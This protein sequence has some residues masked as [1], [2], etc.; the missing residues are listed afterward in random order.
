MT[1]RA[2][3]GLLVLAWLAVVTPAIGQ[4]VRPESSRRLVR[5]WDFEERAFHGEPVPQGWYRAQ[6]LPPRRE[7]P[8]YPRWNEGVLTR[9]TAQSGEFSLMLPTQGG[10]TSVILSAAVLPAMPGADYA[11]FGGIRTA[12]LKNARA[13]IIAWYLDE[14]LREI[15]GTRVSSPL[16]LSE[17]RWTDAHLILLGHPGAAWMEIEVALL[18]PQQ[19]DTRPLPVQGL[20]PG[21]FNGAAY[22]DDLAVYQ[23]PRA[24]IR[25]TAP[26]NIV[27][28]PEP[29]AL[30]V[31]LRDLT[32][33]TLSVTLSVFDFEGMSVEERAITPSVSGRPLTMPLNL[34]GFGWY[35]AVLNVRNPD[36]LVARAFS[37][38][39][40]LPAGESPPGARGAFGLIAEETPVEQF[41]DLPA[42]V[43]RSGVGAVHLPVWTRELSKETLDS[44]IESIAR[45]AERLIDDQQEVTFVL[46]E[47][48]ADLARLVRGEVN[49]PLALL[50]SENTDWMSYLG[51]VLASFGERVRRWQIGPTARLPEF[52][53]PDAPAELESARAKLRRLVPRPIIALPWSAHDAIAAA[54]GADALTIS[55]P[56]AVPADA[57]GPLIRSWSGAPDAT[58]V[59][60]LPG[61]EEYG[62]RAAV[63]ELARR[64]VLAWQAG[65]RKLAIRQPF[66][67]RSGRDAQSLPGA[68][69]GAWRELSRQLA[70]RAIVGEIGVVAGVRA[71]IAKGGGD[72]CLIA[73]NDAA[74]PKDAVLRGYLSDTSVRVSDLFGNTRRVEA[75]AGEMT[76]P[77]TETPMFIEG[78]DAP[79]ALFRAGLRVEPGFIQAR[80]E[81]HQVEIVIENPWPVAVQ[82]RLRIAE[83]VEWTIAPRVVAFNIAPESS[84]RVPIELAFG[85]AEEAGPQT[86]IAE[87]ELT[88]ERRYPVLRM[89]LR[90]E[91]GLETVQLLPSYRVQ[92]APDGSGADNVILTL[93]ISNLSDKPVTLEAF[94]IAP[95]YPA[96]SAPVS[97]LQP[98]TSAVRRFMLERGAATLLGKSVRVGLK[99]LDGTGRINKTVV[100]R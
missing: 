56:D 22:F 23:V 97:Q 91:I 76:I 84:S 65:S 33:E 48:P 1:V 10:S 89:P 59:I 50:S 26:A 78:I 52:L 31:L 77:I 74:D 11:I 53:G 85:L 73:W 62:R 7:R 86:M 57:V 69:L 98:G 32:G 87:V 67:W 58:A 92:R 8:G 43:R 14:A 90:L 5:K 18:Q 17:E 13:R 44:T 49:E 25:S 36:G 88:A 6:D 70:G 100:I 68:E 4:L 2:S 9:G 39:L 66:G 94:A 99:E 27:V 71:F 19:Y 72:S 29:P 38:L 96:F 12:G 37:D 54:P 28:A 55:I 82:G 80:A 21:D 51:R 40:Y 64:T 46:R 15:P 24:E 83:P 42:I 61:I 95:G 75:S 30:E 45:A 60:D 35:R 47:A 79:L 63:I 81:K 20:R 3:L 41:A 16:V 34:P 93:L